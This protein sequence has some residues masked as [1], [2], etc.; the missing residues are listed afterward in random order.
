LVFISFKKCLLYKR[1]TKMS[2]HVRE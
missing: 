2:R 1:L